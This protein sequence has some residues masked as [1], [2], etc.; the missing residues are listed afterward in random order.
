MHSAI[1]CQ[2]FEDAIVWIAGPH[3]PLLDSAWLI[4]QVLQVA[5]C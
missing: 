3:Y 1:G 2:K 4:G 5:Q